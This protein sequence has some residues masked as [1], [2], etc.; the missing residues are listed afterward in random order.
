MN[1]FYCFITAT[2]DLKTHHN[3][4]IC[5]TSNLAPLVEFTIE[6]NIVNTNIANNLFWL[7]KDKCSNTRN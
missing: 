1:Y 7:T 6:Q 4:Y 2:K 5:Q 3:N